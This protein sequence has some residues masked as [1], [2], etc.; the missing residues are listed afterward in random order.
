A[1]R[2]LQRTA[3]GTAE[4][5]KAE[6]D[7]AVALRKLADRMNR[8]PPTETVQPGAA[9]NA[10]DGPKNQ[11]QPEGLPTPG[12]VAQARDL[13]RQQRDL[14]DQVRRATESLQPSEAEQTAANGRQKE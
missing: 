5:A 7:A 3:P 1:L 2:R 6:Q 9:R 13:A 8:N 14:R 12:Q 10:K 4:N 11:P